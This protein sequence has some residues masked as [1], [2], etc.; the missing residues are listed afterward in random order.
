MFNSIIFVYMKTSIIATGASLK[1]FDFSKIKGHKI[2]INNAY[3]YIDYDILVALDD[4]KKHNFIDDRLHTNKV[5]VD[6]Y[7]LNCKG[8][9]RWNTKGINRDGKLTA[10]N[11]SLF[12]AINVSLN[13]GFKEID[14]YGADMALTNGY[15]HFYSEE[16]C[17][18]KLKRHYNNTFKKHREW[19]KVFMNDLKKDEIINWIRI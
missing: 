4:P 14:I 1:G 16:L 12:A 15:V 6:K 19:K 13:L 9:E 3:K 17:N 5:W 2:A 11:G 10:F 8:W 18:E 7:K